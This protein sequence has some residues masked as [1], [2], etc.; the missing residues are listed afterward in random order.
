[1]YATLVSEV[2]IVAII[3]KISVGKKNKSRYNIFI[4]KGEGEEYG[5][6]VS[7]EVLVK[8]DLRKGK[9]IDELDMMEI[10]YQEDIQKAYSLALLYLSH[11]MR[12]EQEVVRHLKEKE[13]EDHIIKEVLHKLY[14]HKYL[15]DLAFA[16]ALVRTRM[17]AGEKGPSIIRMDLAQKGVADQIVEEA[18]TE[19]SDDLQFEHVSRQVAKLA[20]QKGKTS[21]VELKRKM[22]QTLIRKGFSPYIIAEAIQEAELDK[23]DGEEWAALMKQGEKAHRRYSKFEGYE[24]VHK[25]KAA[26][27]RKGFSMELIDRFIREQQEGE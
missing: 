23:D 7:E 9:E 27:Y 22:E 21:S 26:L 17:N 6:S 8:M 3:S 11:R 12:S 4:D 19:Y 13:F 5:F 16:V 18:L 25:M 1:M 24:Y 15:D 2:T 20:K 10:S 14:Q